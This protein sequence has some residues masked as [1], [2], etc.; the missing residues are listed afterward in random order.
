[1]T[2]YLGAD[3]RGFALKEKI[4]S[5]LTDWKYDFTDLGAASLDPKDD[6]TTYASLVAQKIKE[7]PN[8]FGVLLCGSGVGVDIVANKFDGVRSSIGKTADQ[9]AAGRRDDN[10][11]C[12]VLASD[13]TDDT[14]AQSLLKA[15]LETKHAKEVRFEKRLN[16]IKKIEENN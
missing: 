7:D 9:I 14:E 4:K 16:D 15:F 5:W 1:M 10:M 11:N 8:S 3:H 2:L 12:L 6:Y 13:F